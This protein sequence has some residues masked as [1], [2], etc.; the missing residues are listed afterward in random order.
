MDQDKRQDL[1]RI[2]T[3]KAPDDWIPIP[4][5]RSNPCGSRTI[6]IKPL[7]NEEPEC[8]LWVCKPG[9]WSCHITRDE[10]CHFLSGRCTYRQETGEVVEI[11]P[12]TCAFFPKGWRGT[13]QVHET[14]K[15]VYMIP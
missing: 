9:Y 1:S 2:G 11:G 15:K 8:G 10:F 6:Q 5:L 12:D 14:I 4:A 13:C 3:A 7:P